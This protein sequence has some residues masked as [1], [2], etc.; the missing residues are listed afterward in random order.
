M[1]QNTIQNALHT[2]THLIL[3]TIYNIGSIPI[4]LYIYVYLSICH[5]SVYLSSL[6]V[7]LLFSLYK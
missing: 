3:T 5:L 1:Q 4:C 7:L 6:Y 2:L